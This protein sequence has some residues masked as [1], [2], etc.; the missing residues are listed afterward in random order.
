MECVS[1][2]YLYRND[3]DAPI[4]VSMSVMKKLIEEGNIKYV[5]LYAC[6]SNMLRRAYK[7]EPVGNLNGIPRLVPWD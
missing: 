6:P 1:L 3:P 5:G 4:E 7:V 2:V